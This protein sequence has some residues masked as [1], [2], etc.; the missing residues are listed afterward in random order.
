MVIVMMIL[1]LIT[2]YP[3]WH[4]LM[5]SLSDPHQVMGGGILLFPRGFSLTS[6]QLLLDSN[7]VFDAYKNSI[8]RL[9]A[10]TTLNVLM[11]SLLAY[12]LSMK[13][14]IGR[15]AITLFIFFTMLFQGG[16]IP[17]YLLVQ[18]LGLLDSIWAL[19]IPG[20]I[21]AWNFFI[22]KNFFQ[23]ISPEIEESAN[24]DG[25]TPLKTLFLI[26]L[27]LSKPVIAA[28]ALFY[29]VYHWNSYF[30]A[31]L[32][33]NS[34]DNQVLQVFLR[35]MLNS[36]SLQQLGGTGSFGNIHNVTEESVKMA[37]VVISILPMLFIYP[38]VQKY[39]VKGIM[40]GGVKG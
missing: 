11:T 21:S 14:F 17:S 22:M 35:N 39:Y 31:V 34:Q 15:R 4:V 10:G 18:S 40:I 9:V 36:S 28:I 33:I 38:F 26:M 1:A 19:I 3:F 6:F 16:M 8:I 13:R 27:P 30:D 32:Y 25:A 20:A 24:I 2:L 12:P 5:Y 37:T 29:A 7:G 23:A